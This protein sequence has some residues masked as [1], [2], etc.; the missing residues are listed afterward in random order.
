M[1]RFI[2]KEMNNGYFYTYSLI[3]TDAPIN[4]EFLTNLEKSFKINRFSSTNYLDFKKKL[5]E[6]EFI[7]DVLI[8]SC[9]I[10]PDYDVLI[11]EG[12]CGNY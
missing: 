9:K 2:L 12:Y 8:A 11:Y 7:A 10:K 5:E 3:E 4:M 1:N 6:S